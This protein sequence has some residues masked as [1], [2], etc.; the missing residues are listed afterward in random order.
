MEIVGILFC[1]VVLLI[2]IASISADIK[3]SKRY[4]N[5]NRTE[6]MICENRGVEKISFYG[7]FQYRK[8]VRYLVSF[9]TPN[10]TMSQEVLLK[11]RKLQY[12]ER[13]EVRYVVDNGEVKLIDD[14]A[15]RKIK[16]LAITFIIAV[17]YALVL[18]YLSEKGII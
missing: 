5:A 11:N 1:I 7:R 10:G 9:N 17:P 3:E 2:G 15:Y 16:E 13:T 18:V 4:K 6:G 12:G 8:Y 14:I